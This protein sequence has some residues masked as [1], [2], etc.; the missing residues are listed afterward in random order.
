[1]YTVDDVFTLCVIQ[2]L[3]RKSYNVCPSK[4]VKLLLKVFGAEIENKC[5]K[6]I[7]L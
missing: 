1:M 3:T 6:F 7:G 4:K 2:R 5:S